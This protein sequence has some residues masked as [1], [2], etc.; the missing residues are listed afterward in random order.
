MGEMKQR[1]R[2]EQ[3]DTDGM[4]GMS[5]SMSQSVSQSVSQSISQS[6][7]QSNSKSISQSI[8]QSSALLHSIRLPYVH[9][10]FCNT[11]T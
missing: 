4:E 7:S 6:V 9:V 8:I 10:I 3:A 5:Q 11:K 2:E 1:P